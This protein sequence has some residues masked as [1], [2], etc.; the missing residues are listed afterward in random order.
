[1]ARIRINECDE[2]LLKEIPHIKDARARTIIQHRASHKLFKSIDEIAALPGFNPALAEKIRPFISFSTGAFRDERPG[3]RRRWRIGLVL[4]YVATLAA[5]A[6]IAWCFYAGVFAKALAIKPSPDGRPDRSHW[7][8][9]LVGVNLSVYAIAFFGAIVLT[10]HAALTR[11]ISRAEN[12]VGLARLAFTA[13]CVSILLEFLLIATGPGIGH[14]LYGTPL[15]HGLWIRVP[16]SADWPSAAAE[17]CQ[18]GLAVFGLVLV[19]RPRLI[20]DRRI[21]FA[22]E[23]VA[24]GSAYLW[25]R[26]MMMFI[27]PDIPFIL[28]AARAA[29]RYGVPVIIVS[30]L[31]TVCF[32]APLGT[33]AFLALYRLSRFRLTFSHF[34]MESIGLS[35]DLKQGRPTN[36]PAK[37]RADLEVLN[38]HGIRA[39]PE[40]A[41]QSL[42]NSQAGTGKSQSVL[43][44]LVVGTL[45]ICF[46]DGLIQLKNTIL[47]M[48]RGQRTSITLPQPAAGAPSDPSRP[49]DSNE[50]PASAIEESNDGQ[51][52]D[53]ADPPAS[54]PSGFGPE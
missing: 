31:L 22:T 3:V 52:E 30:A 40:Q 47:K 23:V 49:P 7:W 8:N 38:G 18:D 20:F 53:G 9:I 29:P 1:M 39:T 36:D 26:W 35:L 41:R 48:C 11:S 34:L 33:Y 27:V 42:N 6:T 17:L 43:A 37:F 32:C 28:D 10:C 4:A 54:P 15:P 14:L 19:F 21:A 24:I 44:T 5:L 50:A 16:L 13:W 2:E 45:V 46:G 25:C 12:L 51:K